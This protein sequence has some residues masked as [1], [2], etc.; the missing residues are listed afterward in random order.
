MQADLP[1]PIL[2]P[3][4]HALWLNDEL[5]AAGPESCPAEACVIVPASVGTSPRRGIY[6]LQG[7]SY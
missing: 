4:A 5:D 1:S 7:H 6:C 3:S 2:T